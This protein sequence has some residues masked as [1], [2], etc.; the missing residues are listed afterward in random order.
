MISARWEARQ[1]RWRE[2]LT[3]IVARLR[4]QD[5]RVLLLAD[6][7]QYSFD[8]PACVAR[9]GWAACDIDRAAA[10]ADRAD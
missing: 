6:V 5:L 1:P 3:E 7:P 10:D 8:V 4:E 2:D 9:R